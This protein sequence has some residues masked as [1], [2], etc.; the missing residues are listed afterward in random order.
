MFSSHEDLLR[1]VR[2]ED[3]RSVDV[4]FCDLPGVMQ[5]F[6]VPAQACTAELLGE[7]L[8]FD[9]SSIRG[10]QEIHESDMLLRPDVS[11]AFV[12][13]FRAQ[14]TL[15]LNFF[16][17]DPLTGQPYSRDPR[18]IAAKAEA[19]LRT[20]GVADTACFG[21]EAEFYVFDS[22][23]YDTSA[24]AGFYYLDSDEAA[25]N[26]GRDEPGGNRGY[27]TRHKGGYFPV[28]P[29]DQ[30]ADLRDEMVRQL[31]GVGL[32]VERAHHE[33]GTAGQGEINYRFA[34]LLQA[35]DN[36][37]AF[38]YVVKNTA[39]AAGKTA[40]FMPK[41]I[42]GDNGSGMHAHQSLWI[43][44][45]PLFY[46]ESGYAGLSDTARW[47]IGGLLEH[48][49][50]LL[51]F[52]NPTV[53]SYRRL[54]PGYEAP[55]NLV[56]SQRNR[57]AC[58]RIPITGSDPAAKRVEFRVPDPSANPYLAFS[59]MLLAGLD[60]IKNKTEPPEP[61]DRDLYQLTPAEARQ[62]RQVPGSL[63][64]VLDALESDHD[65]LLDGGVFTPDLVETWIS[66]KR[67]LEVDPI[68]LRPTPH[69]FALYFDI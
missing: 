19:H 27:K 4:R 35:A 20:T 11:T 43:D 5:H 28:G 58:T 30:H 1:Y 57:S 6:T 66:M 46:D 29:T 69:E 60:G 32:R 7:G 24:Q 34:T 54:V 3:V 12:D 51:A 64:E 47:Y 42:F 18:H 67:E 41:P 45:E 49:P 9:G 22:V 61:M 17:H 56:Y 44:G 36:L 15:A 37:M 26:T 65:Y 10:F 63:P 48:A 39:W 21:A 31:T 23:R 52:T 50:S 2:D 33:V 53:N 68:R 8:A 25:W 59:A 62:V 40:T 14:K 38:K 16:I 13:P 55:V